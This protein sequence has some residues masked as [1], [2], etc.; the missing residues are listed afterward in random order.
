MKNKNLIT[1]LREG[2]DFELIE[3]LEF[4]FEDG[5]GEELKKRLGIYALNARGDEGGYICIPKG[6][7]TDFGSIPQIFQSLI[8]PVGKPT[9]SYVLHDYLLSL[10]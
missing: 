2:K 7:R 10:W 5:L 8:S 6:F 9:K 4:W 3:D 1:I